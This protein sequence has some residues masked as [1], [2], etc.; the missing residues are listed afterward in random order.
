MRDESQGSEQHGRSLSGRQTGPGEQNLHLDRWGEGAALS[1]WEVQEKLGSGPRA[2]PGHRKEQR[3]K[4]GDTV[5][6]GCGREARIW[7]S[8]RLRRIRD[9]SSSLLF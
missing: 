3:T 4:Q 6:R 9:A 7:P 1:G 8:R 2:K 5:P